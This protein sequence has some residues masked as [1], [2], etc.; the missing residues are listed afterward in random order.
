MR[1][2]YGGNSLKLFRS[3]EA[4]FEAAY[5]KYADMLYR[6]ALS[7]LKQP[8]D[9]QDAVHDVFVRYISLA[10]RFSD[11]SHEKAWF[12]KA[13]SNKSKDF[14]RRKSIR[15]HSSLDDE[16]SLAVEA[17]S[18]TADVPA[19]VYALPEKYRAAVVLHYLED[20]SVAETAEALGISSSAVKMRL[21][22]GR[23][24]LRKC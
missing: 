2:I 22:R 1:F 14:L 3:K 18:D 12:I 19:A 17:K 8:E 10:P 4:D 7:Y 15:R 23:E 9:A 11:E 20:F 16:E 21:M 5:E 24:M 6:V 13:V